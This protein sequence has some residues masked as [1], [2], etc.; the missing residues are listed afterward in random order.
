[1]NRDESSHRRDAALWRRA[2]GPWAEA[3]GVAEAPDTVTLAGYLDGTLEA[4][5]RARVETWMAAS[6]DGLD[7]IVSARR[8]EG[9]TVAVPARIVRRAQDLVRGR[10]LAAADGRGWSGVRLIAAARGV[11]RPVA[12]GGVVAAVLLASVSGFELG[13]SGAAHLAA[14]DATLAQDVRLVMGRT[15]LELL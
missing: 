12:W 7:L 8:A 5:A 2:R 3:E 10:R 11:L 1:M 6:A 9:E 13:R 4:P 14:L 15:P